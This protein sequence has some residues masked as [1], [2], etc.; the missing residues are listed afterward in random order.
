[1]KQCIT[2]ISTFLTPTFNPLFNAFNFTYLF[3][4]LLLK[5]GLTQDVIVLSSFF[6]L[7][8]SLYTLLACVYAKSLQPFRL[9]VTPQTVALQDSVHEILQ[10]R[11]LEWVAM[12]ALRNLPDPGI[13]LMSLISS[14]LA[15]R[16]FTTSA[17]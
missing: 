4:Y 14:A 9:F 11:I 6:S 15:G 1:M 13:K 12:P 7:W 8:S 3:P 2:I 17:T 16:I 10:V 5:V